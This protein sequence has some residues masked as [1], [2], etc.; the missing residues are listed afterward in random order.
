MVAGPVPF[1]LLVVALGLGTAVF[2]LLTLRPR[3]KVKAD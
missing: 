1:E 3:D 2:V